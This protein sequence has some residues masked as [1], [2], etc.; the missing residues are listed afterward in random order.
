[1]GS[2]L[3]I[4]TDINDRGQILGNYDD[5]VGL[6]HGFLLDHGGF[7]TIDV[8][9]PN[10]L[11]TQVSGINNRGQVVGRYLTSNPDPSD[12]GN[13]FLNHGF[14]ATPE[15]QPKSKSP[16][17]VSKPNSF[18]NPLRWPRDIDQLNDGFA[19]WARQLH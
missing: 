16:L 11:F 5:N 1:P 17:L 8:S 18:S 14:I 2:Q 13:P 6:P 7:T 9:F 12:I 15:T 19:K 10:A 4:P 3:T